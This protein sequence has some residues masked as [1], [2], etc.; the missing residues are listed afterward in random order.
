MSLRTPL[1]LA[2]SLLVLTGGAQAQRLVPGL[3]ETQMQMKSSN[4][5]VNAG[6]ARMQEQL[7]KMP[8]DQRK[9]MEA[10]MAKQGVSVGT[11][12][13]AGS[14]R[15]C[16]GKEQAERGETPADAEGRCKRTSVEHSGKTTR[17]AFTCTNPPGSGSG[18]ITRVS[19]KAYTMQ[20]NLQNDNK[21][22]PET[23]EMQHD[24]RWVAADC[25]AL[26]PRQ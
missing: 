21:G 1:S 15:F 24:A 13:K 16:L 4:A 20:M 2:L 11:G 7:A 17:F 14:F 26:K 8:P 10:M 6:M 25:G 19:D 12:G 9:M 5:E 18:T 23:L 22:K 3:W